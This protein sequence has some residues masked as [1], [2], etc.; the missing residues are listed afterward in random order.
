ME[1]PSSPDLTF[2]SRP[3]IPVFRSDLQSVVIKH[4]EW[5]SAIIIRAFNS[6]GILKEE[7]HY[8]YVVGQHC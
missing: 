5:R 6:F 3:C 1:I 2:G 8:H 4:D 7:I